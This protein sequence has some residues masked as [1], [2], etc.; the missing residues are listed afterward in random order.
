MPP[1]GIWRTAPVMKEMELVW[2]ERAVVPVARLRVRWVRMWLPPLTLPPLKSMPPAA[3]LN[4]ALGVAVP[5][6]LPPVQVKRP[7]GA[8]LAEPERMP[9]VRCTVLR[10]G[11]ELKLTVAPVKAESP[12]TL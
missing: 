2:P 9:E 7:E 11:A 5:D 4:V 1:D 3:M 10:V 12:E 8:M 6:R